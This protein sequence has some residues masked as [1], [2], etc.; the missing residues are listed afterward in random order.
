MI[1]KKGQFFWYLCW[2][3]LH[4]TFEFNH[5]KPKNSRSLDFKCTLQKALASLWCPR[6]DPNVGILTQVTAKLHN[7]YPHTTKWR[8]IT[9]QHHMRKCACIFLHACTYVIK[10]EGLWNI[11]DKI[12]NKLHGLSL[13][14]SLVSPS[15]GFASLAFD[16][17]VAK[18]SQCHAI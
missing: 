17:A 14:G 4:I 6:A 2:T 18:N 11:I 3:M 10:F 7:D 12:N 15:G 13:P 16:Q 9:L 5:V 1:L 8:C